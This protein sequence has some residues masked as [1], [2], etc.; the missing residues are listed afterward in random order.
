MRITKTLYEKNKDNNLGK[1]LK[2]KCGYGTE[3]EEYI[4]QDN[5]NYKYL[6]GYWQ[7]VLYFENIQNE[8]KKELSF[9]GIL[10]DEQKKLIAKMQCENSVAVHIRRGDYLD[11]QNVYHLLSF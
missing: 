7:N 10:N 6:D 2:K 11:N 3:F 5:V 4:Y 1:F 9:K 8:L